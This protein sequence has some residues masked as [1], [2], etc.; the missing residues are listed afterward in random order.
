MYAEN[1]AFHKGL[2]TLYLKTAPTGKETVKLF[3]IL[4]YHASPKK[5]IF[6]QLLYSQYKKT[7]VA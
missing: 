4:L 6:F 2:S 1:N 3:L 5:T 7:T